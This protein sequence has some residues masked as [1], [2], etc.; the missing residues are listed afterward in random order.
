MSSNNLLKAAL[1]YQSMG[2]S[3]IPVKQNKRPLIAWEKYQTERAPESQIH[4]WWKKWPSANIGIITG[5][6]SGVDVIDTDSE[7]G[8]AFKLC[9]TD[10]P[11]FDATEIVW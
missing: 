1:R 2:F 11:V 4:Q 8:W 6:V 7:S 10:G 5:K 3:V 9:C